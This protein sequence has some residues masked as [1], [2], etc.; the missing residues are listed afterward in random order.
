MNHDQSSTIK[1]DILLVDDTL[2]N[3]RLLSSMLIEQGYNVRPVSDGRQADS[4]ATGKPPDLILLDIMMPEMDGYEVCRRLPNEY[5]GIHLN[6]R[7]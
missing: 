2:D 1:G 4:A 7:S 6:E 3:L 5:G